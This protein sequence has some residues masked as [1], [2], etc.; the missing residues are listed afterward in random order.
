LSKKARDIGSQIHSLI[1]SYIKGKEGHVKT[2]Y[3][4]EV[5]TGLK[6]FLK[7]RTDNP[8]IKLQWAEQPV[9][10]IVLKINGTIDCIGVV[11]DKLVIIDWKTSECK[12]KE[13]PEIY[14]EYIL[15][16]AQYYA[17]WNYGGLWDRPDM[18]T[19]HSAY[20]VVLAKDKVCYTLKKLN[21]EILN[22]ASDIFECLIKYFHQRK[23]LEKELK[24]EEKET[25]NGI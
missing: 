16:V 5:N 10:D 8:H 1:E 25:I 12:E 4:N 21:K 7:F 22:K 17:L 11:D 13:K 19:V 20:I 15:Q 6:S 9:K 24:K 2:K 3:Q 23:A 18:H 14:F